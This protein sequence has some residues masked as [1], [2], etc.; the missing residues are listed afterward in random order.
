MH[1]LNANSSAGTNCFKKKTQSLHSWSSQAS[2]KD[3][4]VNIQFN[5][6]LLILINGIKKK[7]RVSTTVNEVMKENQCYRKSII[8]LMG[9]VAG[10]GM[11]WGGWHNLISVLRSLRGVLWEEIQQKQEGSIRRQLQ[12]SKREVTMAWSTMT[13]AGTD[14]KGTLLK[15]F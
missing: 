6:W 1:I 10:R 2:G 13:A 8:W 4:Q 5:I 7:M 14:K 3:K 11:A 15:Y 9:C 12:Y